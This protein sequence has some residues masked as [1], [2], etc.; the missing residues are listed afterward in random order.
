MILSQQRAKLLLKRPLPVVLRLPVDVPHQRVQICRTHRKQSITTLPRKSTMML[1]HPQRRRTLHLGHN[2]RRILRHRQTHGD[3]NMIGHPTHAK[4]L[5]PKRA[6]HAC[7]ESMQLRQ[8]LVGDGRLPV[9]R[10]EN[11]MHK[12]QTQRL[13][14]TNDYASGFQPSPTFTTANL[15]LRPRLLCPRAFGPYDQGHGSLSRPPTAT[16]N[17]YI[18]QR[19]AAPPQTQ[20]PKA[21]QHHSLGRRPR[22][23]IH[24]E[25]EG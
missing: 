1:L 16:H 22:Y 10:A 13:R 17:H 21:R 5:T 3:M 25:Q 11:D 8:D 7:D 4:T 9:F 20:G 24:H 18:P 14:H 2:G 19:Q 15:G 23:T 6:H 12:I